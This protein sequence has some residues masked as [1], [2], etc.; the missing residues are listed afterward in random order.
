VAS[1]E[2]LNL[3]P[4]DMQEELPETAIAQ[5]ISTLNEPLRLN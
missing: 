4:Y 1:K 5:D 2:A 3:R